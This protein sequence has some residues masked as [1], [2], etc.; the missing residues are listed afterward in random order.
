MGGMGF[1]H[2]AECEIMRNNALININ[3]IHAAAHAGIARYFYSS[4]VCIYRDMQPGEPE[5]TEAGAYPAM[6]DNE[7][8]WEKLYAERMAQAYGRRYG[9]AV[10]IARFQNTYGPEGTWTGGREKAPAAMCRKVAEAADG[11]TI[12]VWG[13]G[14]AIR[15]YTYVSDLVDGIYRLTQSELERACN[16]GCPQYVTVNELV[17][18]VAKVAGKTIQIKHIDG[19]V[20]VHSRNFAN[21]RMYSIG[22]RPQVYLEAG[23]AQTYPWVAEQVE[24]ARDLERTEAS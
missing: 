20:G 12:E 2:S 8:G 13:D 1:I 7:Y 11:G 3:M 23:I 24:K 19:P 10:R 17:A 21:E 15:S 22:W 6:P 18:T 5:M 9:M 14:S 16:I 4:S